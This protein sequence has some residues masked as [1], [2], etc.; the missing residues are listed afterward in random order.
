MP[1]RDDHQMLDLSGLGLPEVPTI[2]RYR[3]QRAR[4]GLE[5]HVHR[6]AYEL[7]YLIEGRQVYRVAG[8]DWLLNA[9]DG[10]CTRPDEPHD[11]AE[12]PQE[13]AALCWIQVMPPARGRGI[14]GLDPATSAELV[15]RIGALPRTFR[16]PPGVETTF[17]TIF[18]AHA[19]GDRVAMALP[20]AGLLLDTC[21]HAV[22]APTHQTAGMQA[23]LRFIEDNLH[24]PITAT[25]LARQ[26]G[27]TLA[28]FKARFRTEIG[29]PPARYVMRRRIDRAIERLAS[30]RP[31]TRVAADL[32]FASSQH[33]ANVVRRWTGKT[34]GEFRPGRASN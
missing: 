9:G 31:V 5:S 16:A 2:G 32:G 29:Q 33:F 22:A 25:E 18:A 7:C 27:L 17:A 15:R 30:G 4:S 26:A 6:G 23:V 20:I 10:F 34:P 11:T 28:W 1:L 19:A 12:R 8:Q 13:I 24:R 14:L 21:R 3:Y